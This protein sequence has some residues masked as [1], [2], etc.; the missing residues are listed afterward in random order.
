MHLMVFLQGKLL[1]LIACNPEMI[2]RCL[3]SRSSTVFHS[4]TMA[5]AEKKT[6]PVILS[7]KS[8]K[9]RTQLYIERECQINKI[10]QNKQ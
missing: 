7:Q 8:Q 1:L 2:V 10:L 5:R 3:L 9:E 4:V 6:V